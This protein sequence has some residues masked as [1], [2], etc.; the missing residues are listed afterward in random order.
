MISPS[1]NPED[2]GSTSSPSAEK[3]GKM[4][5]RKPFLN[6]EKVANRV[7]KEL[8]EVPQDFDELRDRSTPS[9]G[10]MAQRWIDEIDFIKKKCKTMQ[11]P[12]MRRMTERTAAL[13]RLVQLL[14]ERVQDN[15]DISFLR[16]QNIEMSSRVNIY[17]KEVVSLKSEVKELTELIGDL[18]VKA[19]KAVE[20]KEKAEASR[21]YLL[22]ARRDRATSPMP[23]IIESPSVN[24]Y[25][26][27]KKCKEST[28]LRSDDVSLSRR[29]DDAGTTM[30][31]E[32][33]SVVK[34]GKEEKRKL[35]KE[36]E[37]REATYLKKDESLMPGPP[38]KDV[39]VRLTR[40]SC[41]PESD[42]EPGKRK[43]E[44]EK[45]KMV[46][47][48]LPGM[49]GLPSSKLES[50]MRSIQPMEIERPPDTVDP[51]KEEEGL[52]RKIVDEV[53]RQLKPKGEEKREE[54]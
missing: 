53:L 19:L 11:G 16:K 39:R 49:E 8:E 2:R 47:E 41:P 38:L 12:L 18:Q 13:T 15:G 43:N 46:C 42:G 3:K 23:Q 34:P 7:V 52:V 40:M 30:S 24:I 1:R 26:S 20:D 22:K 29:L 25:G 54:S 37:L 21:L 14:S 6:K 31:E 33:K 48:I 44:L 17:E 9:L 36:N 28:Y 27:C 5:G 45:G 32:K 50:R 51:E 10:A 35:T 4:V